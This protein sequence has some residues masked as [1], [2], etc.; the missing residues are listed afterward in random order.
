MQRISTS[1]RAIDKFGP[2]KDG[3]NNGDKTIPI[4]ATQVDAAWTNAVQEE[5]AGFVEWA[6]LVLSSVDMTQVRQALLAKFATLVGVQN[7]T[8]ITAHAA[9]TADA[10]TAVF[11]PEIAA[12]ADGMIL[13]LRGLSLNTTATPTFT[14]NSGAIAPAAIIKGSDKALLEGDLDG[15]ALLKWHSGFGKWVLL[16]PSYGVHPS[17]GYKQAAADMS[18]SRN[19]VGVIYNNATEA[20]IMVSFYGIASISGQKLILTAGDLQYVAGVQAASQYVGIFGVVQP[21]DDYSVSLSGGTFSPGWTWFE[22]M[23]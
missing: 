11:T 4:A 3:F 12:L 23:Y 22:M 21:G 2:G 5:L 14:P 10:I 19:P 20:P 17:V 1:S 6:G 18:G 15:D 9:G 7:S 8:Y 13:S 16:N